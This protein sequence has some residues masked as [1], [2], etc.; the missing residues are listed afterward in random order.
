M[1]VLI[2]QITPYL[3]YDNYASLKHRGTSLARKR[4]E[5]DLREYIADE[6]ETS[7]LYSYPIAVEKG[8]SLLPI[9]ITGVAGSFERGDAISIL[10]E[11]DHE[12]ARGLSN[13]SSE[14]CAKLAGCASAEIAKKIGSKNYDEVVHRD[15]IVLL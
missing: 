9:G 2:P 10:D 12:I 8:S 4:L 15:N 14:E 11:K 6:G 1:K 5:I 3:I 13:Y 7:D